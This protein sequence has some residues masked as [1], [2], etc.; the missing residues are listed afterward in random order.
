MKASPAPFRAFYAV[1]DHELVCRALQGLPEF[2]QGSSHP[3]ALEFIW[4]APRP[5]TQAGGPRP[6]ATVRLSE[7]SVEI[8]SRSR[9]AMHAMQALVEGLAG[10]QALLVSSHC[11]ARLSSPSGR[12]AF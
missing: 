1:D 2:A 4:M 6:V 5:G 7:G 10:E 12:W 3:D 8:E 9:P 11:P